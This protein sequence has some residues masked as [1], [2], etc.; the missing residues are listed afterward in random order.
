MKNRK[1]Y[2]TLACSDLTNALSAGN[3]KAYYYVPNNAITVTG[4]RAMILTAQSSG[5][6]L[7]ID[8]NEA[9]TTI[10]ST[11]LTIDN[12]ENRSETAA[13]A[14]VISDTAIA[15]GALITIDFDAV[16]SGGAG[17][18]VEIEYYIN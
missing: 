18:I 9:G 8:I 2:I 6:L 14:A 13:T 1:K 7:T 15:A 16:G 4:V 17:V 12:S 5:T 11:K 10:L 3:T